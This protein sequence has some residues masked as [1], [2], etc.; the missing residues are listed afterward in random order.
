[1]IQIYNREALKPRKCSDHAYDLTT[2][3][4]QNQ[5]VDEC[6]QSVWMG[7]SSQGL[8]DGTSKSHFWQGRKE[9]ETFAAALG[10]QLMNVKDHQCTLEKPCNNLDLECE[11]IGSWTAL[12]GGST[13][14]PQRLL[15]AFYAMSGLTNLNAELLN[16]Y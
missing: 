5:H 1:M 9:G 6:I 3:G 8:P 15:W 11:N 4:W 13:E 7:G 2:E 14:K 10:R 16:R 12:E